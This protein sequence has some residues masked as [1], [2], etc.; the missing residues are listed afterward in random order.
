MGAA[1][2]TGSTGSRLST[3]A[4][5]EQSSCSAILK[6]SL[7]EREFAGDVSAHGTLQR[8]MAACHHPLP[9]S[10]LAM[11]TPEQWRTRAH[12]CANKSTVCNDRF[13]AWS[14]SAA[15]RC[16]LMEE[17][18]LKHSSSPRQ[19]VP[20]TRQQHS[21]ITLIALLM[22]KLIPS[23]SAF[24]AG[25]CD[26]LDTALSL[27]W[28]VLVGVGIW[29]GLYHKFFWTIRMLPHVHTPLVL[30]TDSDVL[31]QRPPEVVLLAFAN[32]PYAFLW[33]AESSCFPLS[34]WPHNLGFGS[35][36]CEHLFDKPPK[37]RVLRYP[38]SGGW[39]AEVDVAQRVLSE[40]VH[41]VSKAGSWRGMDM[42]AATGS[43]Q[44]Y[45]AT[46]YLRHRDSQSIGVDT[47]GA[48]PK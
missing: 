3:R 42:C 17:Y 26:L 39:I 22:R 5:R 16:A 29:R 37:A 21:G 27:G 34:Q 41:A 38:N 13:G 15:A 11:T 46:H 18:P 10:L 23:S 43:D 30:F 24:G 20:A 12:E 25:A 2:G 36:V 14:L 19:P 8:A 44:F 35:H 31:V 45:A 48:P 33:S 9:R 28:Q 32:Q 1:L 47:A 4:A 6:S 7:L 40:L